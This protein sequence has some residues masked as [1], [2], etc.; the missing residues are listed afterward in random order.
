[1]RL[2]TL[3]FVRDDGQSFD[4]V[5]AIMPYDSSSIT[6]ATCL[7]GRAISPGKEVRILE[8][9]YDPSPENQRHLVIREQLARCDVV[10][11]YTD[12]YGGTFKKYNRHAKWFIEHG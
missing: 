9:D 8:V 1:M 2:K 12:V 6:L 10:V 4:S 3:R 11:E 7:D 5:A